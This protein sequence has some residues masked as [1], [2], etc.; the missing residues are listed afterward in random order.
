ILPFGPLCSIT[1]YRSL[2]PTHYID[3]I[4]TRQPWE[5]FGCILIGL[6]FPTLLCLPPSSPRM[7][8]LTGPMHLGF[9]TQAVTNEMNL[10][11]QKRVV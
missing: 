11:D 3:M 4:A 7:G 5:F 8:F 9:E 6:L 1:F 10:I 2:C